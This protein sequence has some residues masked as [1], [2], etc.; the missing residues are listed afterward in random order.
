MIKIN[1]REWNTLE[2]ALRY[3]TG[4]DTYPKEMVAQIGSP[5]ACGWYDAEREYEQKQDN[6]RER[7]DADNP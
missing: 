4:H 3:K 7:D 6:M 2:E 5:E 1:G